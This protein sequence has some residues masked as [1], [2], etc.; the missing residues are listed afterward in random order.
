MSYIGRESEEL[1][2]TAALF[3]RQQAMHA[4][5]GEPAHDGSMVRML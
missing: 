1:K 2:I 5:Y 3:S 4:D